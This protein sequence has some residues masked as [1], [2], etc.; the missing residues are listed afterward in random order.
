MLLLFI[1]YV[2]A[3]RIVDASC[4]CL[5]VAAAASGQFWPAKSCGNP[6][7]YFLP[8]FLHGGTGEDRDGRSPSLAAEAML[9]VLFRMFQV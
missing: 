2:K 6:S 8:L 5:P 7:L 1:S 4:L 9:R 3:R